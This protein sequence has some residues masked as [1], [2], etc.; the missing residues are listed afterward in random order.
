MAEESMLHIIITH[1]TISHSHWTE[2]LEDLKIC[3]N[4]TVLGVGNINVSFQNKCY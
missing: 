2:V 1:A 3:V 4:F